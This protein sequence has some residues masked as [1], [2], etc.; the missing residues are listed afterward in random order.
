LLACFCCR[1]LPEEELLRRIGEA[2]VAAG[3][4]TNASSPFVAAVSSLV[5]GSVD[6]LADAAGQVPQ[7]LAY[8]LSDTVQ[9]EEFKPVRADDSR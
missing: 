5:K 9:S 7:L 6:M 3:I 1:A 4:L 2:L 8:P